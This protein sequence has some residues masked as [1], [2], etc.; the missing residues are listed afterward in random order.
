VMFPAWYMPSLVV[1]PP[2]SNDG[3]F[4][5][6]IAAICAIAAPYA[7]AAK[8]I[9]QNPPVF[10]VVAAAPWAAIYASAMAVA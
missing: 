4:A 10:S 1:T 9:A 7:I 8:G 3:G 2:V 6:A 5:E